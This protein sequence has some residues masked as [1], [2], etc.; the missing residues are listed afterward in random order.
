MSGFPGGMASVGHGR[1]GLAP[2]SC[3]APTPPPPAPSTLA[4]TPAATLTCT[5]VHS[6][7]T[8]AHTCSHMHV[9]FTHTHTHPRMFTH[10]CSLTHSC[11]FTLI[12]S[13]THPDTV[14]QA[15][16]HILC[17]ARAH[18]LRLLHT[19]AS[20]TCACTL[21]HTLAPVVQGQLKRSSPP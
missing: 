3:A 10:V 2:R 13:L 17:P 11:T 12:H 15:A 9:T 14:S 16:T 7:L 1:V 6:P 5:H 18:T 21:T 4:H 19:H 8:C 20:H